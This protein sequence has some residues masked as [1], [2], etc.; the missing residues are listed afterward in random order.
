MGIANQLRAADDGFKIVASYAEL[1]P[2][3]IVIGESDPEGCAACQGEQMGYRN[4]TMYS[5]YTAA[6]FPRLLELARQ[7]GVKL[8]SG[9]IDLPVLNVFRLFSRMGGQQLAVT[10]DG[11]V[12]L[13]DMKKNG[14]RGQPDVSALASLDINKLAVLVWY[15]HDDDL[16]GPDAAIDL[17]LNGLPLKNGEATLTQFRIDADHSNSYA[18]W[19]R[20][21][22]PQIPS[23]AQYAEI[24]KAGQ[25]AQLG[26]PE[27]V[28]VNDGR[29]EVKF[30]LPRQGVS[31]LILNW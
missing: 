1:K 17:A 29:A 2:K 31:L 14:V 18:A 11:A 26:Q 5:S 16:P 21:G 7:R 24:E 30:N 28:R 25:L 22:S 4:G 10:S 13:D 9:G 8:A 15:Y 12:S 27:T 3:P 6:I 23:A 19:Q 20:M